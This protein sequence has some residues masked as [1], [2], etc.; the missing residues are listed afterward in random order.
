[1]LVSRISL[2]FA[3]RTTNSTARTRPEIDFQNTVI[4]PAVQPKSDTAAEL[5]EA[6]PSKTEQKKPASITSIH[7][8]NTYSPAKGKF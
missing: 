5:E 1:M 6:D 8:F 4:V 7:F 2:I 3:S